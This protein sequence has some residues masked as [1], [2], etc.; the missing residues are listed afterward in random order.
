MVNGGSRSGQGKM[1]NP[2]RCASARAARSGAVSRWLVPDSM[3]IAIVKLGTSWA[4][5]VGGI[6]SHSKDSARS[7]AWPVFPVHTTMW[8]QVRNT[9]RFKDSESAANRR[10]WSTSNL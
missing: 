8:V 9:S 2:S 6:A 10:D 5:F 4:I 7:W 1:T 3:S